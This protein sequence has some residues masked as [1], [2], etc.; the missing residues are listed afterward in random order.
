MYWH[1]IYSS[2][3]LEERKDAKE[4]KIPVK[5]SHDCTPPLPHPTRRGM[6]ALNNNNYGTF[7]IDRQ[8]KAISIQQESPA[9]AFNNA[10]TCTVQWAI[11]IYL[12]IACRLIRNLFSIIRTK[13]HTRNKPCHTKPG[14]LYSGIIAWMHSATRQLDDRMWKNH[15][16]NTTQATTFQDQRHRQNKANNMRS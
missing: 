1:Y 15:P 9:D 4:L 3:Q 2:R 14:F 11:N 13:Y 5:S 12:R 7:V 16:I 10:W 8:L 6:F